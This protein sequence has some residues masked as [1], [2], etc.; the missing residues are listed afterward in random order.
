MLERV[1]QRLLDDPVGRQL[2]PDGELRR[3]ALDAQLHRQAG[4]AQLTDQQRHVGEPRLGLERIVRV[5]AQHAE[6]APH[7]GQR[8]A[9]GALDRLEHLARRGVL[10]AQP[11]PFGAGLQ[12]HHRDVMG[13]HVVQLARD[14][15]PLLDHR[16]ARRHVALALGHLRAPLTVAD[17]VSHEQHHDDRHDRERDRATEAS[18]RSQARGEQ[19]GHEHRQPE[20][21]PPRRCPHRECI[22]R[23]RV[24]DRIAHELRP[25]PERVV[26]RRE[27]GHRRPHQRWIPAPDRDRRRHDRCNEGRGE[28]VGS[29]IAAAPGV[30]QG[31]GRED[32]RKQPVDRHRVEP[33]TA[34]P[35]RRGTH[36]PTLHPAQPPVISRVAD[37][38]PR[39]DQPTG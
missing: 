25:C 14:P 12:H 3:L 6:Q 31:A 20:C 18:T 21:E 9:A 1:R 4:R 2:D 10:I 26:H 11:A 30:E 39:E 16:L 32:G 8:A 15:R 22:Q 27:Q 29:G 38:G 37:P 36:G 33:N 24:C 34:Q 35:V 7:L 23:T 5:A 17:N 28:P 13:D 19:H